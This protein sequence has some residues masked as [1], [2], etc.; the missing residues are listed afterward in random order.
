MFYNTSNFLSILS[1]SSL[2]DQ[3]EAVDTNTDMVLHVSL[4]CC[5]NF[6][7][8]QSYLFGFSF[9]FTFVHASS[10]K[11]SIA[12]KCRKVHMNLCYHRADLRQE[13]V[14]S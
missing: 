5:R 12:G 10:H 2:Y 6:A 8:N 3:L 7:E 9:S 14:T 4:G 13:M 1:N 11:L